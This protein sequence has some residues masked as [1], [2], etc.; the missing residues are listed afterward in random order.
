M[1]WKFLAKQSFKSVGG[2]VDFSKFISKNVILISI[3]SPQKKATWNKC[4]SVIQLLDISD[5]GI[6]CE[7]S[8]SYHRIGF[9]PSLIRFEMLSGN[10]YRIRFKP[11]PWLT[12]FTISI[13]QYQG[14]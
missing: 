12:E 9:T 6:V 5:L 4:G 1:E 7:L 8:N 11:V 13:W 2:S 10:N 14:N 3:E